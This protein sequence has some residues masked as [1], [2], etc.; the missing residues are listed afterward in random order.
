MGVTGKR[1]WVFFM[2]IFNIVLLF[3]AYSFGWFFFAVIFVP[4]LC[5]FI[6]VLSFMER[7]FKNK[8]TIVNY[9]MGT[10]VVVFIVIGFIEDALM[11]LWAFAQTFLQFAIS[12]V[13]IEVGALD[14]LLKK[15][16]KKEKTAYK[17]IAPRKNT[18]KD[19]NIERLR[20]KPAK[21]YKCVD[22]TNV[23]TDTIPYTCPQCGSQSISEIELEAKKESGIYKTKGGGKK[24]TNKK[25]LQKY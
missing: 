23:W 7:V 15:A 5:T 20:N 21:T 13:L 3:A 24:S 8:S 18:T 19:P 1:I 2:C 6:W 9:V 4:N 25:K 10:L 11:G 22:C 16:E 12:G 17:R 14:W